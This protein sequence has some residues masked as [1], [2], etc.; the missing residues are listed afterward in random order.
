MTAKVAL[1]KLGEWGF[2]ESEEGVDG[3]GR[4][5]KRGFVDG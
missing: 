5:R 2:E 3:R 4:E 1:E